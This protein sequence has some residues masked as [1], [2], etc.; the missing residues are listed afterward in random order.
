MV[1]MGKC[2]VRMGIN[3]SALVRSG[4]WFVSL[5]ASINITS[6][7]GREVGLRRYWHC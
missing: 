1:C 7:L 4:S 5:H 6:E 3:I 2:R